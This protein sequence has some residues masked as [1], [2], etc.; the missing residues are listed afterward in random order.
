[1]FNILDTL[2]SKCIGQVDFIVYND[3][4]IKQRLNTLEPRSLLKVCIE[5]YH[6]WCDTSGECG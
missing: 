2:S 1:M 5:L 3:I 6:F 4:I